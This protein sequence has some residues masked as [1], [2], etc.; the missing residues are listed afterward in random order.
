MRPFYD[1]FSHADSCVHVMRN[2]LPSETNWNLNIAGCTRGTICSEHCKSV[3]G[4]KARHIYN[5][6]HNYLSVGTDHCSNSY[7]RNGTKPR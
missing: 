7:T 2:D 4:Y 1:S 3:P 6:W 5:K